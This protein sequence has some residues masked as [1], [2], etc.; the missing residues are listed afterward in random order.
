VSSP[1]KVKSFPPGTPPRPS[2]RPPLGTT[3]SALTGRRKAVSSVGID[4]T[5]RSW[6]TVAHPSPASS[7]LGA[8]QRALLPQPSVRG[9]RLRLA[10]D[11]LA[12]FAA[13]FCAAWATRWLQNIIYRDLPPHYG[14]F[15]DSLFQLAAFYGIF[16]TLLGYSERL[17]QRA[18]MRSTDRERIVL[19][20]CLAWSA[21]TAGIL[22][23]R[24]RGW[25]IAFIAVFA[26]LAYFLLIAHRVARR[27]LSSRRGETPDVK[28]VL[29][30]G[31]GVVGQ[32][33]ANHLEDSPLEKRA[34]LGFLDEHAPV[35]GRIR[36]RVRDLPLLAETD[37]VDE[38]ILAGV[39]HETALQAI[40]EAR[41]C[42]IDI[43]V[44]PELFDHSPEAPT[45]EQIGDVPVLTLGQVRIPPLGF[46]V[47]RVFDILGSA[48]GL[49]ILGPFLAAIAVAI[50]LDSPGPVLYKAPRAGFKG[51]R[52]NC[53]KFRT[54]VVDADKKK[55]ELLQQN[56]RQ[57]AFFKIQ[58]D[59]RV[60]RVG[61]VLRRYSLDELPQLGNV[62][63]GEMSLVGPRP[64]PLDDFARYRIQDLKRLQA[65]PGMTGLWQVTA[66][67][68]PSFER[69]LTLDREYIEHWSLTGDFMILFKTVTAV[70]QGSG[71]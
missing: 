25:Q 22:S 57:G 9:Q 13:I 71:S 60:T 26:L 3:A 45:L 55:I 64:H 17:Y 27:W 49:I 32:T 59:P 46:A 50:R 69:T 41:R 14:L 63:R 31:A 12:D 40:W 28:N 33:L 18:T 34:V 11:V 2:D 15:G 5:L 51:R 48:V 58:N 21:L 53:Y 36:G 24:A 20:K 1:A 23:G 10:T 35:G 62:L 56:E 54:M 43:K 6:Q 4:G 47:K 37:F 19:A 52:F 42:G 8:V 39:R 68:D 66:R 70:L 30:V 38:I 29:I 65:I 16:F 44:V 61:R 7:V 67:R